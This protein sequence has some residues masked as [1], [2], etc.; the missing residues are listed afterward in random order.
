MIKVEQTI[1]D[2]DKYMESMHKETAK[3]PYKPFF[4]LYIKKRHWL[5]PFKY[6]LGEYKFRWFEKDKQPKKYK[7]AFDCFYSSL[8]L[9]TS[10]IK[11]MKNQDFY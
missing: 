2:I 3:E 5:N 9:N 1:K 10:D 6:I 4:T 11:L 7:N 8:D